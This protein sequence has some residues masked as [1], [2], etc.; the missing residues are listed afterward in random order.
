MSGP[1][2][3]IMDE[4]KMLSKR[5]PGRLATVY[6]MRRRV[7]NDLVSH[8]IRFDAEPRVLTLDGEYVASPVVSYLNGREKR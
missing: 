6:Q 5:H 8:V 2:D 4:A 3:K 7:G 1:S